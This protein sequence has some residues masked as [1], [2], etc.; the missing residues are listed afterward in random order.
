MI[1]DK[2]EMKYVK[3]ISIIAILVLVITSI[4]SQAAFAAGIVQDTSVVA[5]SLNPADIPE[6]EGS[7][8]S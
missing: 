1:R 5:S 6:Y 4:M 7:N 2:V 3:R 8:T